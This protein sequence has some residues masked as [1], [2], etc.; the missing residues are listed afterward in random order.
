MVVCPTR[1]RG[2]RPDVSV[3]S[4]GNKGRKDKQE[5]EEE[6]AEPLRLREAPAQL[7]FRVFACLS[8]Q[9]RGLRAN[10]LAACVARLVLHAWPRQE[11]AGK[12]PR[13]QRKKS[14]QTAHRSLRSRVL[15]SVVCDRVERFFSEM[16]WTAGPFLHAFGLLQA[17]CDV[18]VHRFST[19]IAARLP[20]CAGTRGGNWIG[21]SLV[22]CMFLIWSVARSSYGSFSRWAS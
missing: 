10:R 22:P 7:L 5:E 8:F 6:R 16:G 17:R 18:I 13:K 14:L 20:P 12:H 3:E 4:I 21:V 19:L 9:A 11:C 15:L 1:R 2:H